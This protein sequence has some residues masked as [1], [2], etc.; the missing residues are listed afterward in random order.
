L[1][2][3]N[4][5]KYLLVAVV[6]TFSVWYAQ[7]AQA[8]HAI[9]VVDSLIYNLAQLVFGSLGGLIVFF[10]GSFVLLVLPAAGAVNLFLRKHFYG[11]SLC[12]FWL[13]IN[14]IN[15]SILNLSAGNLSALL[16]GAG[17]ICF[18][19]ATLAGVISS[20][21]PVPMPAAAASHPAFA[22]HANPAAGFPASAASPLKPAWA[23]PRSG[24]GVALALAALFG[25]YTFYLHGGDWL[26]ALITPGASKDAWPND[27]KAALAQAH[28]EHKPVLLHFTGSDWCPACQELDRAVLNTPAFRNYAAKNLVFVEVDM[29]HEKPQPGALVKQNNDLCSE[30]EIQ[31]FPTV[32][33]LNSTGKNLGELVGYSGENPS[34]YIAKLEKFINADG[35]H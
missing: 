21:E 17:Y 7:H 13:G 23:F 20:R 2:K 22:D 5:R 15:V 24:L 16:C 6:A 9:D 19:L 4:S 1:T 33:I 30:F 34:A 31:G 12:G 18:A 32:I 14:L 11:A 35:P 26:G 3:L 28:A 27:F 25:A 8:V 29:P 10:I